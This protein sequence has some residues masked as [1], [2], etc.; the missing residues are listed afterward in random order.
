M[1]NLP[2]PPRTA[3]E[4]FEMLPEGT[5]CEVVENTLYMSPAPSARHQEI[6]ADLVIEIGS[7]VKLQ[8]LGKLLPSPIDVYFNEMNVF[9]PDIVYINISN[10]DIINPTDGK[11][12]GVPNM[13]IEVLSPGN[14]KHDTETKKNVYEQSGV[15]ELWLVD[16]ENKNATGFTLVN[17]KYEAIA[18]TTAVITCK[19]LGKEFKF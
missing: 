12:H 6:I 8:N 15:K 18:E 4:V 3:L 11:I 10:L 7:Y 13:I 9:Q 14:K 16:S 19:L 5:L 17:G 1:R 2:N